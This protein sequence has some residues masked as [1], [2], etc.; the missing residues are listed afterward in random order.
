MDFIKIFSGLQFYAKD[1]VGEMSVEK[2]NLENYLEHW[3]KALPSAIS[4][5]SELRLN[6]FEMYGVLEAAGLT[7]C[8]SLFLPV[9]AD[10]VTKDQWV[11]KV[12]AMAEAGQGR[13]ILKV[14]GRDILH[15]TDVGGV[16]VINLQKEGTAP[17]VDLVAQ[18]QET[19]TEGGLA[20]LVE[21]FLAA[22]FVP[23]QPNTPGQ[24]VLLSLKQDPAFGPCVIVGIG[25]TLT[26][27]YGKGSGGNSTLILPAAGL[28][29]QDVE[30][31]I[32]AH[33]LLSLLC[34]PS[35][36]YREAPVTV[37]NLV[38][39]VL[40]LA[41]IGQQYG[42]QSG[43]EF[44]FEEI[45]INPAV[46]SE[47]SLVAL[48]GVGLV[49]RRK[50]EGLNRPVEKISPLLKPR[51]AMVLGVSGK[52]HNPGRIILD[53][54]KRS[55]G[56]DQ[57]RLYV[58]HQKETTISGIP[59]FCSVDEVPEKCDLAVISVPAQGA[60]D[61]ITQLVDLDKAQALILIPGGFAEAGESELAKSIEDVLAEGHL[62]EGGGPVMVGGNCLGI[63]SRD[64]Y[65]TFFLPEYKLP[66]R[67]GLGENLALVSQSGAYLVTFAS[68][69]DGIINPLASISFGNQMDLTISDFVEHFSQVEKVDVIA[70]YVEGFRSGD[71]NRFLE[72]AKQARKKGKKVIIFKAGKTALGAQAAASHTASLA[73]DYAVAKACLESA[74]V[75][76]AES[77]DHF[78]DLIKTFTLLA[79][80]EVRGHRVGIISNAGFECSTVMDQLEDLELASFGEKTQGLLNEILPPFAH[81]SNPI[82]CTPMT[83]TKAFVGSCRAILE[84]ESVDLAILASVPVTPALNNLP[85]DP[86]GK[87]G[88]D[89]AAENSQPKMM[90]EIINSS[91][92]PAA[93]VVDSGEIYDPMCRV[94]EESGIPVFRKIDRAAR[95]MA[96]FCRA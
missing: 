7:S 85:A 45:E 26:E 19:L 67:P 58:V 55:Q 95:A 50:W 91:S 39:W 71:G 49:S 11:N 34:F 29:S 86:E 46:A 59:C 75:T 77:L 15:K 80:K 9:E 92:K 3:F 62:R 73:G 60:L 33:P 32:Q 17:L 72:M 78:E 28:T 90:I 96:A 42:P 22:A 23:H 4:Q 66:F 93:V 74:G 57:E 37:E 38:S 2:T 41:K 76:V 63:V 12:S 51:S 35:R 82:D 89:I 83:G 13:F 69:Y 30:N 61:S 21:G 47:G 65:N 25:G 20:D 88:E 43:S 5:R 81:R 84:A 40:A 79:R 70:C 53:N 24:E 6:E 68:N 94:I 44:T 16:K 64:N 48:D 18:M 1:R 27:W 10:S 56:I 52:G 8:P 14:V 31:A 87:H 54:L 36:L